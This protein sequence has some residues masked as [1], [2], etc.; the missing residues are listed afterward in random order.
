MRARIPLT[1]N[2]VVI[3]VLMQLLLTPSAD[4]ASCGKVALL[5]SGTRTASVVELY[6]SEGCD[7]CP[8]ADKWFST[9]SYQRDGVVPLAFHVDYWD[10]IG[11]KD[12]FGKPAWAERQRST[13]TRQ[14]SRTVYTPQVMLD[15]KDARAWTFN[16][17]FDAGLRD[18][19][20]RP[21][22]AAL[23]L[24][25]ALSA[26][27]PSAVEVAMNVNI[28]DAALRGESALFI[29]LTENN[30]QSRVTAG[31]NKGNTLKHNHVVRELIGPIPI[32]ANG[33]IDI[34]RRL[35]LAEGW[36]RADLN[37]A[38][39]VQNLRSGEVLQALSAPLCGS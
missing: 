18:L 25:A 13:V 32:R 35:D 9:L 4:A 28:P 8:P 2:A 14:G 15:G 34:Q 23:T 12:P 29:A 7:S 31:E 24:S 3:A 38:G 1:A 21:A 39:F 11:W 33:A 30:L 5:A 17:K 22:R 19:A 27:A 10:Y 37:I 6:T 16:S 20:S 26:S 36:K